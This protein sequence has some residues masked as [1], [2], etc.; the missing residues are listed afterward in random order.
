MRR[1][2]TALLWL[3]AAVGC[4]DAS[5]GD[6]QIGVDAGVAEP[7]GALPT[8]DAATAPTAD[9]APPPPDAPLPCNAGSTNVSGPNGECYMLFAAPSTWIDA[10]A[11]CIALGNGTH[12]ADITTTT[13]DALLIQLA[14]TADA[15]LGARDLSEG[16]WL[17]TDG[18][19]VAYTN[20]GTNEP[21]NGNGSYEEDCMIMRKVGT[22][23]DPN[24]NV[25]TWDDRPCDRLYN[26]ICE[27]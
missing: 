1:A 12:L 16:L 4:S 18:S 20:W 17:W 27:R 24:Y 14:G 25:G 13:E 15:W 6:T 22:S 26:Y 23:S 3:I 11:A 9:A 21:N 7:D 10:A 19:T 5:L 2:A 8:P